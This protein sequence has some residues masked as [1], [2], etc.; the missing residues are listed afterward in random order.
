M[1]AEPYDYVVPYESDIQSALD[2]LRQQVFQSGK[3]FGSQF[4]PATPEAALE[5]AEET[6]TQSILDIVWVAEEP[7]FSVAAPLSAVK[8]EEYFGTERPTQEMVEESEDFWESIDRGMCRYVILYENEEPAKIYFA[9][10][11]YD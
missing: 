6:G 7:N 1:G 8:L 3:F 4:N 5:L 11:S 10:Y 2:K 9:G